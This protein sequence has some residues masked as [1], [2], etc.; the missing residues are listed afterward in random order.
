MAYS[1]I[2]AVRE[3]DRMM[4][5]HGFQCI[6]GNTVVTIQ[7]D[8]AGLY[9]QCSEGKHYLEKQVDADGNCLGL[10]ALL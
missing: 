7:R 2:F 1:K 4:T 3:G 5:F 10:T 8:Y 6:P 9:F